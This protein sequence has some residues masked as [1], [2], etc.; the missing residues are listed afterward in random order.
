MRV[1]HVVILTLIH[2]AV[3]VHVVT[4]GT[5]IVVV[6]VLMIGLDDDDVWSAGFTAAGV[7]SDWFL[8]VVSCCGVVFFHYG[9]FSST[10]CKDCWAKKANEEQND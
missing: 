2:A 7:G 5:V 4:G 1:H 8:V 6:S 10:C 3:G 9:F